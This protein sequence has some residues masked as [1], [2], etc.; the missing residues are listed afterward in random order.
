MK[1]VTACFKVKVLPSKSIACFR[2]EEGYVF[3]CCSQSMIMTTVILK[4]RLVVPNWHIRNILKHSDGTSSRLGS[5]A[6]CN[7][8]GEKC[9]FRLGYAVLRSSLTY[10][11]IVADLRKK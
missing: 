4:C 7:I 11:Y 10:Q 6:Y 8:V 3:I 9:M 2:E 5:M 1:D